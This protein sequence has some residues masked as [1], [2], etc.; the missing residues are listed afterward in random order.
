MKIQPISKP[1]RK[2]N[3]TVRVDPNDLEVLDEIL[4]AEKITRSTF[5]QSVIQQ[6][7]QQNNEQAN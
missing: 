7:I 5:I 6:Y 3:M 1:Q 2:V 4:K